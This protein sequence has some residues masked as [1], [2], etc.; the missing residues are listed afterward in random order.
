LPARTRAALLAGLAATSV[1]AWVALF[2]L[3]MSAGLSAWDARDF[4]LML[5]MWVAMM[6][7]MMIPSAAPAVLIYAAVARKAAR[8][9]HV[10]APTGAFVAGYVLA[11]ALF[12]VA[13][14]LAQWALERAALL[15]PALVATSPRL[16]AAILLAAGLYQLTPWKDA[17][18]R[19][20]R[21]PAYFIAA[22]WRPGPHGALRMGFA[23][24]LTCLGCCWAL[25]ALL[26][27]GGV[28]NLLWIAAIA[29]FVLVEKALRFGRATGRVAGIAMLVAGGAAL[30]GL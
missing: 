4:A 13:A 15:S 14:T 17:C 7:G 1:L 6:I 24:G 9:G 11:W 25:M 12:S 23:H 16:G 5:A 3:P 18:L 27:V 2:Q 20:C 10:V 28:M 21:S 26:F 30:L 19:H 8:D 29:L 22:H